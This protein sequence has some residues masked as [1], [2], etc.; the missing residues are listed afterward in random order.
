VRL[1]KGS[2]VE[3]DVGDS[4]LVRTVFLSHGKIGSQLR[5]RGV[6]LLGLSRQEAR[7]LLGT[8]TKTGSWVSPVSK[9]REEWDR[10]DDE[11]V[12]LHVTYKNDGGSVNQITLTWLA[13]EKR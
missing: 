1:A 2:G 12:G 9:S 8:P 6:A 10:W 3:L 7:S 5:P 11:S 13:A 4:G